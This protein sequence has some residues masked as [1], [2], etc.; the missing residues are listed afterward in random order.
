MLRVCSFLL[1]FF[2]LQSSAESAPARV[3][4]VAAV[5]ND[6]V[7]SVTDVRNRA[8]LA[9]LSSGMES[10]EKIIQELSPQVLKT[11][12][13]EALQRQMAKKVGLSMDEGEID[14]AISEIEQ[15]NQMPSGRLVSMLQ[16]KGIPAK[17]IRNQVKSSTLWREY[18]R[19]RY[20]D[21]VQI[22]DAQVD[23]KIKELESSRKEPQI[24]LAEINLPFDTE[25]NKSAVLKMAKNL[26]HKASKGARFSELARQFSSSTSAA[27]GGDI[28]W[29]SEK[30]L[31]P[32]VCDAVRKTETGNLTS[33]IC[34]RDGYTLIMVRDRRGA[35]ESIDKDTFYT[36]R[37]LT[38]PLPGNPSEEQ[39]YNT[40]TKAQSLSQNA[41]SCSILDTLVEKRKG[42]KLQKIT[43]ASSR[44]MPFELK[45]LLD[46]LQPGKASKPLL[47]PVGAM[48]FMLC[49][50]EE[51]NPETPS[52]EN[53]RNF[54]KG[55]ELARIADRELRNLKSAAFIDIHL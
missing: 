32:D 11:L 15:Q 50:K 8:L 17:T 4:R 1:F 55:E 14:Y 3:S 46:S 53:I 30:S 12:I 24:L 44:S 49:E 22:T 5:V 27:Q 28:G 7:I 43:K 10:S 20:G 36:F 51:Y 31:D 47:T 34:M 19:G 13:E 2:A 42:V 29:V 16:K 25:E 45:K 21:F 48:L 18:I 39:L 33:P 52:R 38:F 9:I 35:G 37:Q 26:A 54:L 40:Y 41:R 6:H 23:R